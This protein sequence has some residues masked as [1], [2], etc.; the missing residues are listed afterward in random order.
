MKTQGVVVDM[1]LFIFILQLLVAVAISMTMAR[2]KLIV[3]EP[4]ALIPCVV[5]N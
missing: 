1:P 2:G 5:R 3:T 4:P